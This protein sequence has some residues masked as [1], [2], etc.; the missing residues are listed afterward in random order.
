MPHWIS[1]R[2]LARLL[3]LG[4][5]R[6]P[7]QP[8]GSRAASRSW[9]CRILGH[10]VRVEQG[11]SLTDG[12]WRL[13]GERRGPFVRARRCGICARCGEGAR[14][15]RWLVSLLDQHEERDE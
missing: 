5:T 13:T 2:S 14:Q 10:R 11:E 6:T 8:Q 1:P 3:R 7:R 9:L 4:G 12:R 15:A